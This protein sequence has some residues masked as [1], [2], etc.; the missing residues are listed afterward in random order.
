[1]ID[2]AIKNTDDSSGF[3]RGTH[4]LPFVMLSDSGAIGLTKRSD[5]VTNAE[6]ILY[7]SGVNNNGNIGGIGSFISGITGL[8]A[9]L[10]YDNGIYT[11]GQLKVKVGEQWFSK[12]KRLIYARMMTGLNQRQ[13]ITNYQVDGSCGPY[14]VIPLDSTR[15]MIIYRDWNAGVVGRVIKKDSSCNI[16]AVGSA[17]TFVSNGNWMYPN[18][19]D[20]C[21]INTDK[22]AVHVGPGSRAMAVCTVS[23]MTITMGSSVNTYVASTV[24]NVTISKVDTD[25]FILT[26]HEAN[27][28]SY[29]RVGTVSGT[30]VTLGSGVSLGT[31]STAMVLG[32][33]TSTALVLYVDN[34]N[35]LQARV[36]SISGTTASLNSAYPI[37][38][39]GEPCTNRVNFTKIATG[40]FMTVTDGS[41]D[42]TAR[43]KLQVITISGTVITATLNMLTTPIQQY[44]YGG[45]VEITTNTLFNF[46]N[47][48]GGGTNFVRQLNI[49][50]T[51]V[52]EGSFEQMTNDGGWM[53]QGHAVGWDNCIMV[54]AFNNNSDISAWFLAPGSTTYELYNDATLIASYTDNFSYVEK[55]YQ[56]NGNINAKRLF[57]GIKNTSGAQRWMTMLGLMAEVR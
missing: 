57:L 30:T 37:G 16:V 10:G 56:I 2:L 15:C 47:F 12:Y 20:A 18:Q 28:N 5:G 21:L 1:M 26:T 45:F 42:G 44:S 43:R 17:V 33:T 40:K 27:G 34:T 25:K 29:V 13:R 46:Y 23:D 51:T 32:D 38:L 14:K 54:F 11:S 7:P 31:S 49:S 9:Y 24:D 3:K 39:T 36:V 50:G 55:T 8:H 19:V 35:T 22:V 6:G 53:A 4:Y 41:S 48:D 52:T